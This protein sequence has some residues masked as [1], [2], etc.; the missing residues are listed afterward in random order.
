MIRVYEIP[1]EVEPVGYLFGG[2]KP[3]Q[4]LMVDWFGEPEDNDAEEHPERPWLEKFI[5]GKRYIKAGRRYLVIADARA[6]LTF[7]IEPSAS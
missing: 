3:I 1:N 2:G 4:F 6:D 7:V 5:R